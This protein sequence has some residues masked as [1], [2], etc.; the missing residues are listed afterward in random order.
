MAEILSCTR[1]E[2]EEV[3]RVDTEDSAAREDGH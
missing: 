3:S 2:S 1:L